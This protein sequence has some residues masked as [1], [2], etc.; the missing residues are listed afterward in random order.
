VKQALESRGNPL[1]ALLLAGATEA[2]RQSSWLAVGLHVDGDTLTMRATTDATNAQAT[3]VAAFALPQTDDAAARPLV[4]VPRQIA[5]MSLYRDLH[6]FY[7]AKDQLFPDRTSGLIFFENMMGIFFSGRDL[8]EEVL[9]QT[10]PQ[11]RLVVAEQQY[12]PQIGTPRVQIPAFAAVLQLRDPEEY[13]IVAE[14]AWQKALGLV[15]FTRGQQGLPGLI[16]DRVTHSDVK[17]TT[18]YFSARQVKDRA[19]LET[20]YNLSPSLAMFDDYMIL[21]SSEGLTRDL[22]AAL[23]SPASGT[24]PELDQTHTLLRLAGSQ[25]GSVLKSN[26]EQMV[27]QNMVDK[28]HTQEQAEIEI[29]TLLT[30]VQYLDGMNLEVGKHDGRPQ[31]V[32]VLKTRLPQIVAAN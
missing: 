25:L 19:A 23:K 12:D 31:A 20:R 32:L 26:R 13:R 6:G 27:R 8:T 15:N 24:Q 2:L 17:F 14:E 5:G 16:I 10:G 21:S 28:G 3:G 9:A 18:A 30:L 7:A 1:A 11:I 4:S 22:I 29:D